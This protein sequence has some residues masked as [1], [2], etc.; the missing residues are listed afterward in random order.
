MNS[1]TE[2]FNSI[3]ETKREESKTENI[4]TN[5][6]NNST[7]SLHIAAYENS[8]EAYDLV[9]D[10]ISVEN[11]GTTRK[12]QIFHHF[13]SS[14]QNPFEFPRQQE[15]RQIAKP[16]VMEFKASQTLLNPNQTIPS[17]NDNLNSDGSEEPMQIDQ[18]ENFDFQKTL[19]TQLSLVCFYYR[20]YFWFKS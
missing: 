3:Y 11:V 14:T 16:E 8:N 15:Q 7:L 4:F 5:T 2:Y 6:K 9:T 19:I 1:P 13:C 18:Q 10:S 12:N 20:N 17:T